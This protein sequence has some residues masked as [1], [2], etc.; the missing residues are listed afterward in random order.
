MTAATVVDR[1][2]TRR[3]EAPE[4]FPRPDPVLYPSAGGPLAAEQCERFGHDG[5]VVVDEIVDQGTV[6]ALL[7]EVERMATDPAVTSSERVVKEPGGDDVR[8]VF[9]VHRISSLIASVV[10]SEAVAGMARQLL[11]SDVYVHQSRVNRKP[12]FVGKEFAWHSDFETWH[13][14]DGMPAARAVSVSIALTPN[15]VHNGSLMI[16]PGSHRTFVPTAGET[17]GD[18]Y[19]ESL[20]RQEIGVP[21]P[22]Q[23]ADLVEATGGEIAVVTGP[24]GSAVAFDCNAMHGSSSNITPFPRTNLFVVFNSVENALV[25]PFAAPARRPEFIASRDFTPLV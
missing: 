19:R 5:F 6:A 16:V 2:P 15:Y 22:Q 3:A 24:A 20:R 4:P 13:A 14:E 18:H 23:L 10:A 8:S 9:E 12:G 7:A 17:P 21:S 11:G 1:Y 25:E